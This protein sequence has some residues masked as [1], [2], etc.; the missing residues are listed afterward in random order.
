MRA[1]KLRLALLAL[2][3]PLVLHAP[4]RDVAAQEAEP[5]AIDLEALRKD[6]GL[7][8]GRYPV[9]SRI[10]RYL[11]AAAEAVD[12]G[13]TPED[14]TAT[15]PTKS[16]TAPMASQFTIPPLRSSERVRIGAP[17]GWMG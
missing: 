17:R 13:D 10:S 4:L 16:P 1:R 7:K 2:L 9:A 3:A 14:T 8:A 15:P 11:G 5:E 6:R 12:A